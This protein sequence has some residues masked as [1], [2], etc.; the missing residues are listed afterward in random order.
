[1][2]PQSS[3]GSQTAVH[4]PPPDVGYYLDEL[5]EQGPALVA[6]ARRAGPADRVP[7]CPEWT[8]DDLV[9]HTTSVY[10]WVE[11][12]VRGARS[13]PPALPGSDP[14]S[15]AD[16]IESLA[17]A[18][19]S[20]LEALRTAP[21]GLACWTMWP[22][23]EPRLYWARRM[24]HETVVHAV[25]ARNAGRES[26]LRGTSLDPALAADGVDEMVTGFAQRYAATLRATVP[27]SLGLTCSETGSRWWVRIGPD[28]PEF[29]RGPATV[30]TE[31]TAQPG[32]LLLL[33]WNRRDATGLDVRGDRRALDV[34]AREA[35]L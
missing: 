7:F 3:H 30:D 33:L 6:S 13:R 34:W 32:E 24:V 23:A 21:A 19:H 27:T 25:D 8:L 29:G 31:V 20:V 4:R 16:P 17:A 22:A 1:M 18:H 28:K 9:T 10:R 15:L 26:G 5:A 35:H 11:L 14:D 2:N 12:I